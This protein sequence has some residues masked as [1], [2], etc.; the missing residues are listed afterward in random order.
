G[1]RWLGSLEVGDVEPHPLLL[2]LVPPDPLLSIAPRS[3][4]RVGG[5]AVVHDAAVR[6][7]RGAP[8]EL[9]APRAPRIGP[10]LR[11]AVLPGRRKHAAVDPRC[12]GRGSVVLE[13]AESRHVPGGVAGVVAVDLAQDLQRIRLAAL[14]LRRCRRRRRTWW[15]TRRR[16]G[17]LA[18][19]RR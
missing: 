18:R 3:S 1:A 12:A 7:P 6:R 15:L 11:R 17:V 16:A 13:I 10:L 19:R 14:V 4:L 5:G 2:R 8:A 9:R